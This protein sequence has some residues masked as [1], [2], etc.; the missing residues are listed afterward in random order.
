MV[1]LLA[2]RTKIRIGGEK[3]TQ[4]GAVEVTFDNISSQCIVYFASKTYIV[5]KR[6]GDSQGYQQTLT[7]L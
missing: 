7:V 5:H 1:H 2:A 6:V 4:L 3:D